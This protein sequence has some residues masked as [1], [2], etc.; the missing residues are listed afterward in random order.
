M[1]FLAS[2]AL[3]EEG[4][5]DQ[6]VAVAE[7]RIDSIENGVER[8]LDRASITATDPEMAEALSAFTEAFE[9]LEDE[10]LDEA[11]DAVVDEF[12]ADRV[13]EPLREIGLEVDENRIQPTGAARY[14]QS[15]YTIPAA[16]GVAAPVDDTA[17]ADVLD[18]YDDYLSQF[19]DQAEID[20]IVL[21]SSDGTIVYTAS[22]YVDL[23]A[24]L[25]DG[26]L[27]DSSLAVATLDQLPRV[28]A[29][30]SVLADFEL[31]IPGGARPAAFALAAVEDGSEAIGTLGIRL[32]VDGLNAITT[33]GGDWEGVG[34]GDGETYAVGPE[35]ILQ[36]ES[37]LWIEDP[38]AYL[39]RIDDPEVAGVIEFVGSPVGVQIV[40]T[41]PVRVAA[42]G[43]TFEGKA[44][45][46]VGEDTFS[47]ARQVVV[48]G[49]RWVIVADQPADELR[50]PLW[51]YA[52]RLGLVLAIV[53]PLA[54]LVGYVIAS[55]LTRSI[56]PVVDMAE[57]IAAG[58]RDPEVPPLG[59]NEFGDLAV[60]LERMAVELGRQEAELDEE[61][62]QRRRLLLSVLPERLVDGSGEIGDTQESIFE[63]TVIAVVVEAHGDPAAEERV[64]ELL[65]RFGA[66]AEADA[67]EFDIERVRTA[68]DRFLFV[69]GAENEDNGV[70]QAIGFADDLA[71]LA[72]RLTDDPDEA[73]LDVSIGMATG[74]VATG[75][76]ERGSL[77]FTVWGDPVRRA[78]AIVSLAGSRD[79]F[80]D[81]STAHALQTR[82]RLE[83]APHVVALDG[84]TMELFVLP[85]SEHEPAV[86]N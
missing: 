4:S 15:R 44:T 9:A 34:M 54:A 48:G 31:Y 46:Y 56:P 52:K 67:E 51:D 59:S 83:P 13:V 73:Q 62:E 19:T 17:Y 16:E 11:D 69:C 61:F 7:G 49:A 21:I 27:D 60:Q 66:E 70:D 40:D 57:S 75:V 35:S 24:D 45:N 84:E 28:R 55:R 76:L 72:D 63:G 85:R 79:T 14:L 47:Y 26:P 42:E 22:K 1:N 2:R 5:R 50:A 36:S 43:E 68:A 53:L 39:D 8:V 25:N 80:V 86:S 65:R 29:G 30:D 6:L 32:S 64:A 77:T 58:E 78:M 37:R 41:E 23:G 74:A 82:S 33:A 38:Q 3:L 20:D 81:A 71:E 12:Y 18:Q 10:Q